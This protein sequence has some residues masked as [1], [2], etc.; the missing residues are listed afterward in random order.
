[1]SQ[2]D[3]R[4]ESG[5]AD[6]S[7]KRIRY[8]RWGKGESAADRPPLLFFSGIGANIDLLA[9]F[10]A[11][12]EREVITFDVP[13]VGG[14]DA[15]SG[16]YRLRSIAALADRLLTGLGYGAIDVMGVSWGG[17]LAQQFAHQFRG[18]VDR[19][20]LAATSPGMVM[21]PGKLTAL[22][23]MLDPVRYA[24]PRFMEREFGTLYGGEGGPPPGLATRLEEPRHLGYLYQILALL[25]WTSVRFLPTIPAETLILAGSDDALI[26]PINGRLLELLLRRRRRETIEGAGH[27]FLLTHLD[28]AVQLVESF[29]AA[30]RPA[31]APYSLEN[32]ASIRPHARSA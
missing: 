28:Q 6:V 1:M 21:V 8:A 26:R 19:L 10:L 7:G 23:L 4:R 17:M 27:M 14:S 12:L 3:R 11:R 9:P 29:L 15:P 20:V 30:A 22:A 25:G 5:F 31:E 16:P 2:P 18:R 13:G 32:S 24:D